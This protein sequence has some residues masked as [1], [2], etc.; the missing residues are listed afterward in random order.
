MKKLLGLLFLVICFFTSEKAF[1]QDS[2]FHIYL[3]FGQSNMQGATKAEAM[4]TIPVSGFEMM[5]PMDCPD[6]NRTMGE[7]YPA[8]PPLASCNAGLSPA[9]YFGRKMAENASRGTKI[10]VINVAVGGCKIEL[11]D[12]ENYKSYVETAPD[13]MLN[14]INEYGGNPYGRLIE[15]AKKAQKD[16][17]IKGILLHQGESNTGDTLWPKKVKGVYENILKDLNLKGVE[18]PLLA[19]ELLSEDQ[20]GACASMNEIIKTLPEVIPNS[21]IIPSDGCEGIPD[22]LH[23]SASGYRKLGKRYADQML[24]ILGS[25]QKNIQLNAASPD[26]KL[27]L[28]VKTENGI[29]TYNL[30]YNDKPFILNAPLGLDTNIGDFTRNLV[31]KDNL[32]ITPISYSY[33][34]DKIKK[35][36]INYQANEAVF[37]FLKDGVNAFD[38]IFNLSN[39]DVAFRYKLYPH[40]ANISCVIKSEATGFKF[41]E[42]TKSFL[43]NMMTPMTGFARTAPSYESGYRA[44]IAIEE[45]NAREGYV[46]PGLFHMENNLWV[47]ISETGVHSQYPASH[48]SNFKEGVFTVDFPNSRQNNGFGSSGAQMGLPSFTPWRTITVG[49]TLKPIVETTIPFDVVKPLYEPTQEYN[50]GR[51]TWSWIIWQDGSMNYEDQV[52]YIDLAAKMNYEYILIDAWWDSRIGYDRMEELITYA[53]GKGV[54]VFLWYNSNGTANDAFQTPINKMNTSIARKKEMKWLKEAGVKGIKADFFGGDKQETMRLYEDILSN[55]NDYGLMVVFHGATLPRGWERMFPNFMGSEAVL[56]SEMLVFSEDV[57]Q[58]EAFYA[59]LHPFMRNAVG[60]MEFGGTVLNTFFNKGNIKGQ[61]RLTSEVFQ[62]ATSVLYQNPIQFFALTPNNLTDAPKWALDFMKSVPTTWD[63]TLF[64]K[65]YPGKY[66]I[67]ARRHKNQ[68]YI[69]G[70]NAQKDALKMD[71]TLPMFNKGDTLKVFK[72]DAKLNGGMETIKL[73]KNNQIT[74]EIPS[75]GGIILKNE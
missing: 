49:E 50:Y 8:I 46:F 11:Y 70:V 28:T 55:A 21:Y 59:T 31:L 39:N 26:S 25:G 74:I 15:L 45:N 14:W 64:L 18:V 73:K 72:D 4:D 17:V 60:S 7:W 51:G 16:G 29:P 43:S 9:D 34:L 56:A 54:D 52:K 67:L 6:L 68:W 53:K 37:T 40:E 75:M 41:P 24:Q 33:S 57:R 30:T 1:S 10:G 22:R 66:A 23:F 48:L 27:K 47:L 35:S 12:K 58:K 38:L 62:L 19:G 69:V 5:S 2:N 20:N 65:G 44:D 42:K 36:K 3:C 63:E 61:K 13:W 32:T 71:L